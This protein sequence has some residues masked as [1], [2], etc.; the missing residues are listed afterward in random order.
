MR[1]SIARLLL[2]MPNV[3]LCGGPPRCQEM[4]RRF[5]PVRTNCSW[6]MAYA[7]AL[8][9]RTETASAVAK[10][11]CNE[12][13]PARTDNRRGAPAEAAVFE[14]ALPCE[15]ETVVTN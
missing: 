10:R 9:R 3:L 7:E 4:V 5:R 1:G 14:S 2:E 13:R 12:V 8:A 11:W 15:I 6:A